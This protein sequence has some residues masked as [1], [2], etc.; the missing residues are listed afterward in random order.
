M[1]S[2]EKTTEM[3][4]VPRSGEQTEIDRLRTELTAAREQ[5]EVERVEAR[6]TL[7]REQGEVDRLQKELTVFVSRLN[8]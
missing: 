5:A 3:K 2:R 8:N 6:A 7:K 4:R 1:V